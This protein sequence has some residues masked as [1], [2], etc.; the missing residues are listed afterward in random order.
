MKFS[1]FYFPLMFS[2]VNTVVVEPAP[3]Y[4]VF[5]LE[6]EVGIDSDAV[7]FKDQPNQAAGGSNLM[8]GC[9]GKNAC[10]RSL[11]RF[12]ISTMPT[13]SVIDSL[14]LVLVPRKSATSIFEMDILQLKN[15]WTRTSLSEQAD[16]ADGGIVAGTTATP[17]DVTWKFASYPKVQWSTQGGDVDADNIMATV[18]A[19]TSKPS[20]KSP[21]IFEGTDA[22][23]KVVKGWIDGSIP[24]YGMLVKSKSEN[25]SENAWQQFFYEKSGNKKIRSPKLLITYTSVTDPE[26]KETLSSGPGILLPGEPTPA[27]TTQA[28]TIGYTCPQDSTNTLVRVLDSA[29]DATIIENQADISADKLTWAVG[30][31]KNGFQRG[32]LKFPLN[33]FTK[34]T[35]ITCAEVILS[36]TGPCGP[37]QHS[38]DI[39]MFV[40]IK[41][42]ASSGTNAWIEQ[43]EAGKLTEIELQGAA[44]NTG[45]STWI[46]SNYDSANPDQGT[47]WATPGGDYDASGHI[48]A[49]RDHRN[50]H[51]FPSSEK[52]VKV[53]Q[54]IID[55]KRGNYG[56]L[57][58]TEESEEYRKKVA[59]EN[60]YKNYDTAYRVFHGHDVTTVSKRPKL[61]LH[62]EI[63]TAPQMPI[64][65]SISDKTKVRVT[66]LAS[67]SALFLLL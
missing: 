65:P 20:T 46:Y 29:A 24:N 47:K 50:E 8:V 60:S 11:L 35:K 17:G 4:Q 2:S 6:D 56:F 57:L 14:Y 39:E 12:D 26:Q 32:L 33:G 28:P 15:N 53:I 48:S 59:E 54:E 22:F 41:D 37:C 36:P 5:Y 1:L 49:E 58:K 23:K 10:A 25:G 64:A 21:T 67:I 66:L 55:G 13:D 19:T 43:S 3:V 27:P 30:L 44:A 62:Y 7:I 63:N 40:M 31:T 51:K 9:D 45:D 52:F 38:V 18:S 42:W 34:G 16:G 61:V